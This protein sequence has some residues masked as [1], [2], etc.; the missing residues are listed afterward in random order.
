M[1]F[2]FVLF[3]STVELEWPNW[4]LCATDRGTRLTPYRESVDCRIHYNWSDRGE[5]TCTYHVPYSINQAVDA[6][7]QK[8]SLAPAKHRRHQL[9]AWGGCFTISK[10]NFLSSP[11]ATSTSTGA[12][13]S[14][15][16]EPPGWC[17]GGRFSS[18][19]SALHLPVLRVRTL[20]SASQ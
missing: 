18:G 19:A 7:I 20:S 14:T 15:G 11:F 17:Q 1:Q 9:A 6:K 13:L 10:R 3:H 4:L 8:K 5:G 16:C 12:T 2:P